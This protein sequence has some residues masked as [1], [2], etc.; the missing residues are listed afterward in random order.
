MKKVRDTG[1]F[2]ARMAFFLVVFFA[3]SLAISSY[4]E[5]A[6]FSKVINYQ[7]KLTDNLGATVADG[8]YN[9]EFKLYTASSGGSSIWTNTLIQADRIT[10]TDGLFSVLLGAT[11]TALTGVN[12]D[13]PLYMSINIGGTTNTVSP[14]WDGEM[15]PRK[16]LS[17]APSAFESD[18]LDALDSTQFARTDATNTIAT[19]SAQ[20][21]L[22]M[23]QY[24]AGQILNL[25]SGSN[26][27]LTVTNGG[28][29]S[30]G[31]STPYS[32]LSVWGGGTGG[33]NRIFEITDS[34]STT[35]F[36]VDQSGLASTTAIRVSNTAT[37]DGGVVLNSTIVTQLA[38]TG[39]PYSKLGFLTADTTNF[40]WNYTAKR[41]TTTYASTTALSSNNLYSF[42]SFSVGGTATTTINS[43]GDLTV[44][45]STTLQNFTALNATSTNLNVA[46][47][48]TSGTT[49]VTNL[50]STNVSTSTFAGGVQANALNI[51]SISATSTFANGLTLTGGCF[52]ING[53][54]I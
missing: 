33:T 30:I 10:V 48:L 22:T 42:N 1:F 49:T 52:A 53:A 28:L 39:V 2:F 26:Q 37:I 8:L 50:I 3:I 12:F 18:K 47:T 9:M 43:V 20:T 34:A 11:S 25:F 17:A 27:V 24:G 51:T 46:N 15:S 32:N 38:N 16:Q 41:L 23:I 4:S 40:S 6:S 35:K 19:S 54:C 36:Y 14:T 7:G 21:L 45:G 44:A 29:T 31:T 5:A 13:Q